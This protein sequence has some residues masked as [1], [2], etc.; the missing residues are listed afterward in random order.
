VTAA[1][2]PLGQVFADSRQVSRFLAS[3]DPH[4]ILS[5]EL[6]PAFDDY[7]RRWERAKA[8]LEIPP[9][10]LHVDYEL[11]RA[12]DLRCP[13][14]LMG[15]LPA[16]P[17][18]P[19]GPRELSPSAV[20][21]LLDE[22]A[23]AGQAAMGFGGLWE[24]LTSPHIARLV[25]YGR[26]KGLVDAMLNTSALRLAPA[27][28]ADLI[29]AGLTRLMISLD[30][31]TAPTYRLMRPG[32]DFG[33]VVSNLRELL[34]IRARLKRRLPLVRLS[35]CVTSLNEGELGAF[36]E[37]WRDQV[38]FLSIQR[39]GHFAGGGPALHP[40]ASPLPAPSGRCA[41]PFKRLMVLH[42]GRVLPCCDLS[43]LSLSL[44]RLPK[45]TLSDVWRGE[46]LRRVRAGLMGEGEDL[47]P[48]CRRCQGKFEEEASSPASGPS[49][50]EGL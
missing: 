31:A 32:S 20:E 21:A 27:V 15:R 25:A 5:G 14:C 41:Q 39:Y 46:D 6:G 29:E 43:A 42:D 30:A 17:Q 11:Q 26:S 3:R 22:G 36:V 33:L 38:D 10:P 7:R 50:P 19:D 49:P 23:A 35:F 9:F 28:S 47:P 37:L 2:R 1:G 4:E 13:M 40:K 24:P 8:F 18:G 44:G 12:C 48:E 45:T 34:A 16:E